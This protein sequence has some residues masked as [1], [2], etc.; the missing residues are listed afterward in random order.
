MSTEWFEVAR[1]VFFI[2][3]LA[4]VPALLALSFMLGRNDSNEQK[5]EGA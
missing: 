3:W 1:G 4:G 2:L 5:E